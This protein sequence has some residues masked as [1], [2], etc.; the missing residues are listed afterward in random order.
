MW[1]VAVGVAG[2]LLGVVLGSLL[3]A[4]AQLRLQ[5]QAHL[6]SE[7]AARRE[8]YVEYLSTLRRFRRFILHIPPQN[9]SVV[10]GSDSPRGAIPVI[11]G[12]DDYW[13][14]V[15]SA[16]SRLWIVAGH[17]SDVR[18]ASDGVMDA[19]YVLAREQASYEVG[20]LPAVIIDIS[21]KAERKFADEAWRD[22]NDV[23]SGGSARSLL[24]SPTRP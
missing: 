18:R 12:A 3:S 20:A 24:A 21:R 6:Q 10:E 1:T 2:T 5:Q 9:I 4:R 19:L 16:R 14:A 22:L 11:K 23:R 7:L 8:A 17:D 15:E 13:D